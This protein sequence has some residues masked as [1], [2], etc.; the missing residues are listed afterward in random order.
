ML[1]CQSACYPATTRPSCEPLQLSQFD[2]KGV[3]CGSG[4]SWQVIRGRLKRRRTWSTLWYTDKVLFRFTSGPLHTQKH[5]HTHTGQCIC[6]LFL[7]VSHENGVCVKS[8]YSTNTVTSRWGRTLCHMKL[9][10][11]ATTTTCT[12][13][14]CMY[15]YQSWVYNNNNITFVGNGVV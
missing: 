8:H 14:E 12:P 15:Y 9:D 5:T 7:T 1:I 10:H 3:S 4:C 11:T 13:F 6:W 2:W